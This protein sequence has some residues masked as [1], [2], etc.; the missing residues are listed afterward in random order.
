M[1]LRQFVIS[2]KSMPIDKTS[3][4][5]GRNSPEVIKACR[6]VNV[7]LFLSGNLRRDVSI[8]LAVG[9]QE[10]LSVFSFHG[11]T[12][13]RVSPDERS[14]A[15]FLLKA[16]TLSIDMEKGKSIVMDNGIVVR[17]TSLDT[18]IQEWQGDNLY[19]AQSDSTELLEFDA[20]SN[21]GVFYYEI[22]PGMPTDTLKSSPAVYIPR[23]PNPERFILDINMSSDQV[24]K[25]T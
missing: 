12:L 10:D 15:F 4:K 5:S 25:R 9:K 8:T 1:G 18:L 14:I 24:S 2:F 17:R 23:L 16:R 22:E 3:V 21:S 6:C 19:I 13:R 20:E 7:G 11:E